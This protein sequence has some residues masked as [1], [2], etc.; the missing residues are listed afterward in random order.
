[1]MTEKQFDKEFGGMM[2]HGLDSTGTYIPLRTN[3]AIGINISIRPMVERVAEGVVL[4]GGKLRVGYTMD[5]KHKP[6]KSTPQ[7]INPK[8]AAQRLKDF[9]KG[10]TWQRA[11]ERRFS[12]I[13]GVGI[14]ATQYDGEKAV[15]AID[16]KGLAADFINSLEKKYK[17]YNEVGFGANKRNAIKALNA[18][19]AIKSKYVFSSLP[20]DNQSPD[21]VVGMASGVLNQAQKGYK[22]NV[23]SFNK[24]VKS[25]TE[26]NS[27]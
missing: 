2:L 21:T 5:E 18:A 17:Q 22:T 26:S 4:Y 27:D 24:K 6:L 10:F 23:L 19:W 14:A 12:T 3:K 20:S 7:N 11:D 15:S 1:M 9:C 8:A 25:Q 16:E 13:V